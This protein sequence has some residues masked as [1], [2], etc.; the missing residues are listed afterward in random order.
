MCLRHRHDYGLPLPMVETGIALTV[1]VLGLL[2]AFE[3]KVRAPVAGIV[4]YAHSSTGHAHGSET[5]AMSHA[6]GYVTGFPAACCMRAAS[7]SR[8]LDFCKARAE[9]LA[10]LPELPSP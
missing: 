3:V 4:G 8:R 10:R 9:R 7:R 6:A 1:A 2:V 5:P